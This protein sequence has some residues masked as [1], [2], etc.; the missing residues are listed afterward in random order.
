MKKY[1]LLIICLSV[2]S[3]KTDNSMHGEL[4][5]V[6]T[7]DVFDVEIQGNIGKL[8]R[9]HHVFAINIPQVG[10]TVI[11]NLKKNGKDSFIGKRIFLQ[12][13]DVFGV[14]PLVMDTIATFKIQKE[15]DT[16]NL[17]MTSIVKDTDTVYLYN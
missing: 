1:I 14:A 16:E 10:D 9:F 13:N 5:G 15:K 12:K 7:S 8:V 3:C 6:W 17:I 11:S 4:D 2:F